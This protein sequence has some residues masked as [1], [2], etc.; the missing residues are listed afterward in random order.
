MDWF[1]NCFITQVERY[2]T[3]KN[4]SFKVLLLVHNAPGHPE[5]VKVAHLNVEVIFLS[6]NTT[7]LIQLLD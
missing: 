5:V 6:P 2:L 1:H 4:L 7:S 3:V